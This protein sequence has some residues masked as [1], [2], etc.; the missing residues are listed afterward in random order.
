MRNIRK[1]AVTLIM[2]CAF[3]MAPAVNAAAAEKTV[4][5]SVETI[6]YKD[7]AKVTSNLFMKFEITSKK[8]AKVTGVKAEYKKFF[9]SIRNGVKGYDLVIPNTLTYNNETYKVDEVGAKA[10]K[11]DK[12]LL[13]VIHGKNLKKIGT[14]AFANCSKLV[15]F[16]DSKVKDLSKETYSKMAASGHNVVPYIDSSVEVIG[17]KAFQNCSS[18]SIIQLGSKIRKIGSKAFANVGSKA[19]TILNENKNLKASGVAKDFFSRSSKC[20]FVYVYTNVNKKCY[21]YEK[22]RNVAGWQKATRA[23]GVWKDATNKYKPI[24]SRSFK[25]FLTGRA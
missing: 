17:D 12:K 23:S 5:S 15:A 18:L 1:K 11:G 20:Q 25:D 14:E 13:Y 8:T 24:K 6:E 3:I 16:Y 22:A 7:G 2:A 4:E 9:A 10:F 19:V 21:Y